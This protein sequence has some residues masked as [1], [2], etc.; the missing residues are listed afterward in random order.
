M[1]ANVS[2]FMRATPT[3]IGDANRV[4]L[5]KKP[6]PLLASHVERV[7][8]MKHSREL[9]Q[10]LWNLRLPGLQLNTHL[11][12]S[13]HLQLNGLGEQHSS[14]GQRWAEIAYLPPS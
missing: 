3:H 9:Q 7:L 8:L 13:L 1:F 6:S 10:R 2:V 14:G 4:I 11:R 5:A 12:S